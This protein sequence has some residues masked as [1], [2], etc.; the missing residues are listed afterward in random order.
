MKPCAGFTRIIRR[1]ARSSS[2]LSQWTPRLIYFLV[3]LII[4]YE[5]IQFWLSLY[6]PHGDLSHIINGN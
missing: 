4:A 6:G 5:I 1:K 2:K 3:A